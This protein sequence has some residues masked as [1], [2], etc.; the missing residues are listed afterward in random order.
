MS[1]VVNM[2]I[3][4]GVDWPDDESSS[5]SSDQEMGQAEEVEE[6]G[7]QGETKEGGDEQVWSLPELWCLELG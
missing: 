7:G 4:A 3:S 6:N 1:E 2:A 5:S